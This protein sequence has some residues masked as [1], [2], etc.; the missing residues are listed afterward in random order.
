[1]LCKH[2][3]ISSVTNYFLWGL[4]KQHNPILIIYF[5]KGK[6]RKEGNTGKGALTQK[7]GTEKHIKL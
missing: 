6:E 4:I 1:M 2:N 5:L 3:L 7:D